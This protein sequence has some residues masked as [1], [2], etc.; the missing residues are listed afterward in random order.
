[1]REGSYR[2]DEIQAVG[3][4]YQLAMTLFSG[5]YRASGKPFISHLVGTASALVY[6]RAETSSVVAGLLHSAYSHGEFGVFRYRI[7]AAIRTEVRA[8][9]GEAAEALILAY[10]DLPWS[11]AALD[12]YLARMPASAHEV[13]VLKLRLANELDDNFDREILH[14]VNGFA[15]RDESLRILEKC[16]Q[17][18]VK[19][20]IPEYAAAFSETAA[21]LR[22]ANGSE[23]ATT[24]HREA[25]RIAPRS[26]IPH[27]RVFLR[28]TVDT[29][30][31]LGT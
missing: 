23:I 15:Q 24:P 1:M 29:L 11:N 2:N 30:R 5:L 27:P 14:T 17:L 18:A 9:A 19:L 21:D 16:R 4:A 25:F 22:D 28:R 7:S 31:R 6:L 20:E 26:H 8:A 3:V 12:D 10:T 13:T